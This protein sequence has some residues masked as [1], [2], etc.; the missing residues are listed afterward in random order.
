MNVGVKLTDTQIKVLELIR[1]NLLITHAE[2]AKT[3]SVTIK[4]AERATK[5][6]REAG[7]I[8]REG[9]DKSG[10]WILTD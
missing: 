10:Q 9:S 7:I 2:I 3:L 8:K 6:L 1:Q 4:T 5:I